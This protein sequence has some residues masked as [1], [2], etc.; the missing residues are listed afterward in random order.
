MK[1]LWKMSALVLAVL[2]VFSGLAL[3]VFAESGE[4]PTDP[5]KVETPKADPPKTEEPKADPP[6]TEELKADPPKADAPNAEEPKPTNTDSSAPEVTPDAAPPAPSPSSNEGTEPTKKPERKVVEIT[7][8]VGN[9]RAVVKLDQGET[10]T[11]PKKDPS[12]DGYEFV[13]WYDAEGSEKTKFGFNVEAKKDLTLKA[14]FRK[15]EEEPAGQ[16]TPDPIEE[17]TPDPATEPAVD[18]TLEPTSDPSDAPEGESLDIPDGEVPLGTGTA[19][20][21]PDGA[22]PEGDEPEG[23]EPAIEYL[24]D[25]DGNPVLDENGNP[26]PV[27][28]EPTP[29]TTPEPTPEPVRD[30]IIGSN[31]GATVSY[32]DVIVLT[33]QLVNYDD[34]NYEL[35]WECDEGGGWSAISGANGLSYSFTLDENNIRYGY[36]LSVAIIG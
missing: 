30:V 19:E 5:P 18:P 21:K 10:I 4:Q 1:K 12:K 35:Q 27:T 8:V 33:G 22:A 29:E 32:G 2:L 15:I 26:I 3:T 24:L 7:F 34:A 13:H 11:K 6:K 20:W 25:E 23:T 28:P 31:V 17:P 16:P 14:L 9:D 36:R